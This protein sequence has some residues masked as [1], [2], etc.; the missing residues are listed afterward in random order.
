MGANSLTT[1]MKLFAAV[2]FAAVLLAVAPTTAANALE[3][4][5]PG[6]LQIVT[7]GN[8]PPL[9]VTNPDGSISGFDVELCR[10]MAKRLEL[11]PVVSRLEFSAI[12]PGLA[13]GRYDIV[14]SSTAR[15]AQRLESP[16]ILMSEPTVENF[17]TLV[18]PADSDIND[19]ESVSGIRIGVVRGGQEKT[20]VE[21]YYGDKVTTVEYPGLS[22]EILDL[23]NGRLD[24]VAAN[25]VVASYYV[26][27]DTAIR[28]VTPGLV[29]EGM[30]PYHLGLIVNSNAPELHAKVNELLAQMR[31]DG[32]FDALYKQWIGLD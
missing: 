28:I 25:A 20:A 14:C 10:E 16:D 32:T 1:K 15:T 13:A 24:A 19:V 23:K 30:S 22:E 7:T 17:T 26:A 9:S 5:Q 4:V 21:K 3:L 12:L 31:E 27:D 29:V 8:A 6:T 2:P 18:V 11:E